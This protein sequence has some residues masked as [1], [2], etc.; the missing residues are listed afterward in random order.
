MRLTAANLPKSLLLLNTLYERLK[1]LSFSLFRYRNRQKRFAL[2][3]N[4]IAAIYNKL[5]T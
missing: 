5:V 1:Y 3:F 4:F 2:L